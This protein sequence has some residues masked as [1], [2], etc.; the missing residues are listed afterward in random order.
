[1]LPSQIIKIQFYRLN[2][3][4]V[5]IFEI[6]K[7]ISEQQDNINMFWQDLYYREYLINSGRYKTGACRHI[8]PPA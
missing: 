5:F 6:M 7:D 1:M 4:C 8:T 3:V 2:N